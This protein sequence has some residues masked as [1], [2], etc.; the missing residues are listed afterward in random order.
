MKWARAFARPRKPSYHATED[1]ELPESFISLLEQYLEIASHLVP[2]AAT[3]DVHSPT[4]WHPDLHRDNLF[5]D[6]DTNEITCII[7]WQP[8]VVAPLFPPNV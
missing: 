5:V 6:P 1:P 2:R 3:A 8:A 7:D 4:L